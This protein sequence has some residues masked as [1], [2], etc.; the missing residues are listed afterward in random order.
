[1]QC[2][3][4]CKIMKTAIAGTGLPKVLRIGLKIITKDDYGIK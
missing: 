3:S 2:S 4:C 1:M